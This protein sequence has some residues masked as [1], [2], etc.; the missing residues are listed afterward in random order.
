MLF[1]SKTAMVLVAASLLLAPVAFVLIPG[2]GVVQA[3]GQ[4][5]APN[6][7][8]TT[9]AFFNG[10][11]VTVQYSNIY[12]CNSSGPPTGPVGGPGI[13]PGPCKVGV[14]ATTDPVP[15]TASSTLD[16]I[17][18]AYLGF[19]TSGGIFDPTLGANNVTQ[20]PDNTSTLTCPNHP[21]FLDLTPTG[22][23]GVVALPIHSHVLSN[24]NPTSINQGGWWKLRVWLVFDPS[25]FPNPNTGACSAGSG[26]LTSLAALEAASACTGLG[27]PSGCAVLGPVPT[28]I[29]LFFNVVSPTSK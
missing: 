12:F 9:L 11:V 27:T 26:C 4:S 21:N 7:I 15:D 25:V 6:V 3:A 14:D 2:T 10:Q 23:A 20:C 16:V 1:R 5:R 28:T 8:A 17:V 19:G 18:P 29:Y 22:I 13:S 24:G